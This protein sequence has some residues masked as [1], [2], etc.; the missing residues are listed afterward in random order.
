MLRPGPISQRPKGE[1]HLSGPTWRL[2]GKL[3]PAEC[4]L[5]STSTAPT[6]QC[7]VA[8]PTADPGSCSCPGYDGGRSHRGGGL[9]NFLQRLSLRRQRRRA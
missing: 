8:F 7:K 5:P 9:L 4:G 2:P 1:K 3:V 6:R